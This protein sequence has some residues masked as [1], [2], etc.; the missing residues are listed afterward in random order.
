LVTGKTGTGK[1]IFCCQFLYKGAV[2]Y[3]EPGI[4][5]TT[6]ESVE[7]IKLDAS[8]FGWNFDELES[9]GKVRIVKI[10]PYKIKELPIIIRRL[11]KNMKVKRAVID[12]VTMFS[13]YL[14][15]EYT[16]RKMLY[17]LY[18]ILSDLKITSLMTAEVLEES[19]GLSRFG[20]IEFMADGVILLEYLPMAIKLPRALRIRKMR[21]TK[22]SIEIHPMK[23][24]PKGIEVIGR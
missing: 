12:S 24:T 3:K 18:E 1:T 8:A 13:L 5:I 17:D 14:K 9:K 22:H 15:D 11:H 16:A 6:E 23:I 7:K 10:S 20:L 19:K 2:E 4:Y 21:R